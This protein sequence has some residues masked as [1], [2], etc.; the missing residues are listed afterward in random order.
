MLLG[1]FQAYVS[2]GGKWKL[3]WANVLLFGSALLPVCA[4]LEIRFGLP[5][6]GLADFGG[7]LVIVAMLAM[8]VGVLRYTG[9][10]DAGLVAP[11]A[12]QAAAP[13]HVAR[14]IFVF[15]GVALIVLGM[16]YG[17]WYAVFAEHQALDAIGSSL[18]SSFSA[19]AGR[20]AAAAGQ[21]LLAYREAKYEYDRSVDVHGHWIGLALLLLVLGIAADRIRLSP[22]L[23]AALAW[24]LLAGSVFFPL[25]VLFE[26]WSHGSGP[27]AIA[28][29]GAALSLAALAGIALGLWRTQPAAPQQA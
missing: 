2:L 21:S 17:L 4:L 10:L 7:L 28:I 11:A 3:R 15:G 13:I 19:A 29:A 23:A 14:R 24:A 16:A 6:G 26:T 22:K 1:F 12:Q 27:R 25:G 9:A 18:A 8:W 20:N 5:A